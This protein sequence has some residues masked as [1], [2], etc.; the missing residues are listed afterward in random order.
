M[1]GRGATNVPAYGFTSSKARI[2][3]KFMLTRWKRL[4]KRDK[5]KLGVKSIGKER[6]Y[7]SESNWLKSNEDVCT[8]GEVIKQSKN[9]WKRGRKK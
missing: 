5:P 3:R 8:S 7:R 6:G 1:A 2:R 9:H 4:R